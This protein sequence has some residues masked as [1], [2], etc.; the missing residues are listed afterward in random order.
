MREKAEQIEPEAEEKEDPF[1]Q[2]MTYP[3]ASQKKALDD[4]STRTRISKAE[5]AR[6]AF[7]D[8]LTKHEAK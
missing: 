2:M 3:R 1:V 4:L 8:L 7:A 5:L 6:E